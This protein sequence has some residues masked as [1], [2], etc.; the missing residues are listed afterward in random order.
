MAPCA[1][2]AQSSVTLYGVLDA[3]V[4]S[5]R[6]SDEAVRSNGQN[7]GGLTTSYFGV[8][9]NEDLSGGWQT[10]FAFE[11]FLQVP[12]GAAGRTSADPFWSRN[13]YLGFSGPLGRVSFGRQMT[14]LYTATGRFNS[15]GPSA[16]LSPVMLQGWKT[17]YNPAIL[18][19]NIWNNMV[20]YE[21]P[22]ILGFKISG[23]YGYAG[24]TANRDGAHNLSFSVIYT[25]G[26]FGAVVSTQ[27]VEYGT[28]MLATI[29]SQKA[30]MAGAMY[31]F[32]VVKLYAQY[33]HTNATGIDTTTGTTQL[34]FSVPV[35]P[36]IIMVE[37]ARTKRDMPTNTTTR[38][39][40]TVGY[41]YYLSKRTDLYA[42]YFLDKLTGYSRT[43]NFALGMRHRF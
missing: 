8:R 26:P 40:E 5:L 7:N 19:D 3:Y 2:F 20:K 38:T 28:G 41:S 32:K 17:P 30:W 39:M 14:L 10:F 1:A 33:F 4:G 18:G 12:T 23:A 9:G 13:A 25:H 43:G 27:Q 36:G 29:P 37:A 35:G 22:D 6:R 11:S 16:N 34:G 24:T 15:F 42:A 21:T 31:D